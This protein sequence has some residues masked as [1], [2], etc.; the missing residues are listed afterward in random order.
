[1]DAAD[2]LIS[3][4]NNKIVPLLLEYYMNDEK[5]I[6]S[7]LTNAGLEVMGN[8]WPIKITGR[9]DKSI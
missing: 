4:I 9:G 3:R 8:S 7:I 2:N 1:M 5:E 6:K